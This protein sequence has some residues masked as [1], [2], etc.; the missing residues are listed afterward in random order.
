MTF[1]K[2]EQSQI[3]NIIAKTQSGKILSAREQELAERW[4]ASKAPPEPVEKSAGCWLVRSGNLASLLGV[5]QKTI[6]EWAKLGMPRHAYGEY[7]FAK[8]FPWWMENINTGPEDRDETIT[9]TK[10]RFWEEKVE[11]LR[12]KNEA[13]RGEYVRVEDVLRSQSQ[14]CGAFKNAARSWA[15]RLPPIISGKSTEEMLPAIRSEVDGA[16]RTLSGSIVGG[17]KKKRKAKK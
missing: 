2:I 1:T 9:A 13:L 17:K 12:I 14:V 8:V 5:T 4:E 10:K 15:S 3:K 6:A 7:D 11:N 16:L